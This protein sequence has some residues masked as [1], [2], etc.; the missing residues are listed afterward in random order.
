MRAGPT[1]SIPLP[2]GL[3]SGLSD[4]SE[5]HAMS[6]RPVRARRPSKATKKATAK[7]SATGR[8]TPAKRTAK[9]AAAKTTRRAK[10]REVSVGTDAA[11]ASGSGAAAASAEEHLRSA[12]LLPD[13]RRAD[14]VLRRHP[15]QPAWPRPLGPKLLVH[16]LLRRVGR[17][18]PAGVHAGRQALPR[19]R[20]RRGDQQLA[21]DATPRCAHT[22]TPRHH[23]ACDPRSRWCS[24]TAR[25]KTSARSWDTT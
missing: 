21:A 5:V 12:A 11:F 15:V 3:V 13:Q 20:E 9:V 23:A 19:V 6:D 17:C 1:A 24:S 22:S 2:R 25:P 14:P 4:E 16:H 8:S 18:A 7:K 10:P